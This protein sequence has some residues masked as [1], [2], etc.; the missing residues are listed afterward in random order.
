MT[1]SEQTAAT[2]SALNQGRPPPIGAAARLWLAVALLAT[3]LSVGLPWSAT[4]LSPG[5]YLPG[6]YTPGFCATV[7]DYDGYASMDCGPGYLSP[8]FYLSGYGFG[9]E[10]GASH[11]A[12]VFIA[13]GLLLVV[14]GYRRGSAQVLTAAL[15][16]GAVGFL[17]YGVSPAAGQLSFGLALAALWLALR[18]DGIRLRWRGS[19]RPAGQS[20]A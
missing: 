19:G 16:I 14:L 10:A 4:G 17:A 2:R 5:S 3:V 6:Y 20:V 1:A 15:L 18:A 13:V 8:G 11:P 7:Y 12:R 9:G